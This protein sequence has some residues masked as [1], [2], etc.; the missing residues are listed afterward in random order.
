MQLIMELVETAAQV[1]MVK[2]LYRY[3][4]RGEYTDDSMHLRII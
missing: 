1:A 3:L 2:G 4:E